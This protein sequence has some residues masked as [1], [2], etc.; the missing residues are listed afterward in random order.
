[1]I[2]Q[3]VKSIITTLNDDIKIRFNV[4][5]PIV[6]LSNLVEQ[7]GSVSPDNNN[8]IICS[9]VN[10]EQERFSSKGAFVT[11]GDSLKNPPINLDLYLM[12]SS[13]FS[14]EN[15][16]EGLR[17]LSVVI[18]FFQGRS[19]FTPQNTPELPVSAKKITFNIFNMDMGNLSHLWGALGAK[20][21][22]SIIYQVRMIN[23]FEDRLLDEQIPISKISSNT[24][25]R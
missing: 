3:V 7:D 21:M 13:C 4:V 16:T 15:Y 14:A 2:D 9:L 20:Y 19:I 25:T 5:E 1:M 11:S 12:F 8:K 6:V 10:I 23:I 18:G 24:N 17:F 22:P